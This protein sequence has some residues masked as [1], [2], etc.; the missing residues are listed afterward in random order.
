MVNVTERYLY[1]RVQQEY[2]Q[3]QPVYSLSLARSLPDFART[4][5]QERTPRDFAGVENGTDFVDFVWSA[6]PIS[7]PESSAFLVRKT[8]DS[9]YEIASDLI[10]TVSLKLV[11]T[12]PTLPKSF[13]R[14]P[15]LVLP[16][17]QSLISNSL[18]ASSPFG[19]YA[20]FDEDD[21][22]LWSGLQWHRSWHSSKLRPLPT[23]EFRK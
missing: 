1:N 14:W 7:Y 12:P 10:M 3:V 15:R 23:V 2:N 13:P 21:N 17:L 4:T 8:K 20:V 6:D 16:W 22:L 5:D 9:G 18:R 11:P 19:G